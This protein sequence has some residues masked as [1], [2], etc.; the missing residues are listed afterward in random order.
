MRDM[1][2]LGTA[3]LQKL[4]KH[5]FAAVIAKVVQSSTLYQHDSNNKNITAEQSRLLHA[6]VKWL[7]FPNYCAVLAGKW[8]TLTNRS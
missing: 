2:V 6:S 5:N 1:G 3:M 7:L 8:N 4:L